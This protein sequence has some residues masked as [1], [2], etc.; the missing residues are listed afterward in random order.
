[1]TP[2][3]IHI[4]AR[5]IARHRDSDASV[6][7]GSAAAMFSCD[8]SDALRAELPDFDYLGYWNAVEQARKEERARFA[9]WQAE[10]QARRAERS[11]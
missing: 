7:L 9:E 6:S 5:V 11:A 4:V 2:T 8:L 1:V 10:A 3:E